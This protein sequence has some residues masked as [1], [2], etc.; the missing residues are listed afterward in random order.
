M[1]VSV[2]GR[3]DGQHARVPIQ[4]VPGNF[5]RCEEAHQRHITQRV[6]NDLQLGARPTE[7]RAPR[8]VQ[9]T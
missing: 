5:S 2:A 7:M 4:V 9:L 6:P 3:K 1:S 8:P